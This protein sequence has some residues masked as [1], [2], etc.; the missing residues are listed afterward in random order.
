MCVF[1]ACQ[2]VFVHT[3]TYFLFPLFSP[4][5]QYLLNK[6]YN[7]YTTHTH[8]HPLLPFFFF[9]YIAQNKV[10]DIPWEDIQLSSDSPISRG[11]HKMIFDGRWNGSRV[12]IAMPL[13]DELESDVMHVRPIPNLRKQFNKQVFELYDEGALLLSLHHPNIITMYGA[14]LSDRRDESVG[15]PLPALVMEFADCTLEE[16]LR[17]A[18]VDLTT[19]NKVDMMRDI[20]SGLT[21]LHSLNVFH[22]DI[23]TQNILVAKEVK[24][25]RLT[26]KLADF[27]SVETVYISVAYAAPEVLA[28]HLTEADKDEA[29]RAAW[30]HADNTGLSPKDWIQ[31]LHYII[32]TPDID[33]KAAD[34]YSCGLVFCSIFTKEANVYVGKDQSI[35]SL[36]LAKL[37]VSPTE[38]SQGD[39]LTKALDFE[40]PTSPA[41]KQQIHDVICQCYESVATRRPV[42]KEVL[43]RLS[44][45]NIE[46]PR[47]IDLDDTTSTSDV[48]RRSAPVFYANRRFGTN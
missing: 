20:C 44:T 34:V 46:S 22:K 8:T 25:Q 1:I 43:Q 39:W 4:L 36:F 7:K 17:D 42:V 32:N 9:I 18:H 37:T 41:I 15:L 31:D 33:Y 28:K 11:A 48:S 10:R 35:L 2:Y 45:I 27:S 16:L 21:Y 47:L 24:G 14:T 6:N 19:Q 30:R 40:L 12:A 29:M 23:K 3:H 13:V 5:F 26:V 38:D